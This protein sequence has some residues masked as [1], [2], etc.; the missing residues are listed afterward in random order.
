VIEH[1]GFVGLLVGKVLQALIVAGALHG[2]GRL[3]RGFS[4]RAALTRT[5]V[6]LTS[7]FFALTVVRNLWVLAVA[8]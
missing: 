2:L 4:D 1:A 7:A 3:E 8:G 5:L 6:G